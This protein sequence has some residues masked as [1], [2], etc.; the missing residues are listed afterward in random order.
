MLITVAAAG[1][2]GDLVHQKEALDKLVKAFPGDERVQNQLGIYYFNR[3]DYAESIVAFEKA[4]HINA[5]FSQPYNQLGYAYRFTDRLPEAEKAFTRY[6]ELIPDDPN[7]Y[8]SYAELLMKE[9]KFDESIKSYQKALSL[10]PNFVASYIGIG[11]DQIFQ[12]HGDEARKTFA[13]LA[14]TARTDGERRQALFWTSMTYAYEGAWDKA[15]A[16]VDK[17]AAVAI[18]AH[19]LGNLAN[20]YNLIA[21][22][23]LE[24]GRPDDAAAKFKTQLET[25]EK[26]EVPAEVKET[27]RRLM[28]YAD[29]RIALA[30]HDLATA[31]AK[32]TAYGKQ[33]A[34]K[35]KPLEV[36]QSHELLGEIAIADHNFKVAVTELASANRQ[37]PRVLY[38]SAVAL[39]GAG[40]MKSA[41]AMAT[42]VAEFNGLAVTYAYVRSKAKALQQ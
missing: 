4:I 1:G 36:L 24:A 11:N 25:S 6:I 12:G 39:Q 27:T 7:P 37:D 8:D 18:A 42:K 33:V 16:E 2:K 41:K 9:G 28:I 34:V 23:L 26:A 15:I 5:A 17:E 32:A 35:Q 20:D 21:N 31:K 40:D 13:K 22:Y 10:D 30:K 19:D 29:A 14:K 3:Q 38:L